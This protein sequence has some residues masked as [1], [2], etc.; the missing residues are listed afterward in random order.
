MVT[1][2][3]D[4]QSHRETQRPGLRQRRVF[5]IWALLFFN[6]LAPA[7]GVLL[8]IPHRVSQI[9]TQA[10]LFLAVVLAFTVNPRLRIRRSWFL[11]IYTLLAVTSLMMSVRFVG[12]G[13]TYRSFRLIGF[14]L[15]LWLLT[16]WWGR[17]DLLILRSHMRF[18]LLILGSVIVGL[19]IAPGK[20]LPYGRLSGILWPI[21]ATQVAHY[22]ADIVGLITLLWVC[23]LI[24]GRRALLVIVPGLAV[25]VL[26][27][28]R[29]ALTAMIIG[30]LVGGASLL[31][32][33]QRVRKL[34]A[35]AV[36]IVVVVGIPA[37]PLLT[38]WLSRGESTQELSSLTGRTTAWSA[39][40][41]NP[42]PISNEIFGSGLSNDAVTSSTHPSLDGLAIDSSWVSIYQDQ[43]I[44]GEVLVAAGLLILLLK[45]LFQARGPTHAL[46]LFLI[47]YCLFAG[48]SETGMGGASQYLLDLT[49][50]AS[51]LTFP[52][53]DGMDLT[54]S[55]ELLA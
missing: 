15:V 21:P 36:L 7:Q 38:S 5:L 51:L 47:V 54:L 9:V 6:V 25:L 18:L 8:P 49:A 48:I 28:T 35:G 17:R 2:G 34:F 13:A 12:L 43:G 39:V 44:V 10:A 52:S 32:S 27:H 31:V 40:L 20:A 46:A 19:I 4:V 41:S 16:P 33:K 24:P 1:I 23:R 29:T 55:P 53:A 22:A 30:L 45:A 11:G 14:L 42:R 50:A 37:S 26:T 3:V